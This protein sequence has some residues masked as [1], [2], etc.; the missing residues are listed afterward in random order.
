[1]THFLCFPLLDQYSRPV[2]RESLGQLRRDSKSVIS[3]SAFRPL[4]TLHIS[5]GVLALSHPRQFAYAKEFLSGLN[6]RE[7]LKTGM[8][9]S[10][11]G[12]QLGQGPMSTKEHI[13]MGSS[14][15]ELQPLTVTLSSL[16]SP[17]PDA[18][19]HRLSI[20]AIDISGRL[21]PLWAAAKRVC[22]WADHSNPK[23]GHEG[24]KTTREAAA[25]SVFSIQVVSVPSHRTDYIPSRIQPGK[26][27]K[28]PGPM[29]DA[30]KLIE[31]YENKVWAKDVRIGRLS[32]CRLGLAPAVDRDGRGLDSDLELSEEFSIP[33]P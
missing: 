18:A 19:A 33:L 2:L 13:H 11:K 14:H 29:F 5:L 31:Q 9:Y 15:G 10:D 8:V 30:R 32:V 20:S 7:M 17:D 22:G 4:G 27:H 12:I 1:M 23:P 21:G 28:K 24:F 3:E 16:H 6:I 25:S 26:F